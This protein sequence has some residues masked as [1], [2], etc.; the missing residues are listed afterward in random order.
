M[1][2]P[3][4]ITRTDDGALYLQLDPGDPPR[5]RD[6]VPLDQVDEASEITALESMTLDF[7]AYGRLIGIRIE[8]DADSALVPALIEAANADA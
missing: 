3:L 6:S 7:D 5:I 2:V 8:G 1:K 4:G